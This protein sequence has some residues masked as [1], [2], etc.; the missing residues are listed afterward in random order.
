MTDQPFRPEDVLPDNEDFKTIR[1]VRVR[2][3]TIFAAMRNMEIVA[4]GTQ[5]EKA[6]ALAMIR[7]LAPGLV[8]LGVHDHFL[9]RNPE[10]QAILDETALKLGL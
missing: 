2:K 1:G 9:C 6:A 8:A 10:I 5:E 3:G 7:E 4:D